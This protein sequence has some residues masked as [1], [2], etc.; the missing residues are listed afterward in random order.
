MTLTYFAD[1]DTLYIGL[2]DGPAVETEDLTEGVLVDYDASRQIVG[3][4]I[5]DASRQVNLAK[6]E[7]NDL[8]AV[9]V[10]TQAMAPRTRGSASE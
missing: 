1:T 5:D 9:L 2:R 6:L 8:P 3:I 4:T 10:C 7:I